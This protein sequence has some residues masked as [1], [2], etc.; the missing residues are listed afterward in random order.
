MWTEHGT[1]AGHPY[2]CLSQRPVRPSAQIT[3]WETTLPSRQFCVS[4]AFFSDFQ[5]FNFHVENTSCLC[6]P[7]LGSHHICVWGTSTT[8]FSPSQGS[9]P[10][11]GLPGA[12][13]NDAG[14]WLTCV[15]PLG[16]NDKGDKQLYNKL[17]VLMTKNVSG[18]KVNTVLSFCSCQLSFLKSLRPKEMT[19]F[20]ELR[21]HFRQREA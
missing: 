15:P 21:F 9:W 11:V 10:S 13:P 5:I 17:H 2:Q 4:E 3:D 16:K 1:R 7:S 18:I 6:S 12:P 8:Q 19:Y 14:G 20:S